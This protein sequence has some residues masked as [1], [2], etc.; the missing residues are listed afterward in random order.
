MMIEGADYTVRL[1]GWLAGDTPAMVSE[2]ADG[3]YNIFVSDKLAPQAQREAVE[4]ELEHIARDDFRNSLTI[5]AA[6]GAEPVP[7]DIPGTDDRD[8]IARYVIQFLARQLLEEAAVRAM[9]LEV[10]RQEA[11]AWL[12]E[13][14]GQIEAEAKR[15]PK[16]P[17]RG[18]DDPDL[19]PAIW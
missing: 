16:Y 1:A 13:K 2:D 10:R 4:H 11:E 8:V 3:H 14:V 9:E 12:Q 15:R 18:W 7:A 19:P 5:R 6:E 17:P